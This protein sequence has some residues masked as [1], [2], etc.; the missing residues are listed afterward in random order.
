VLGLTIWVVA[1]VQ[2]RGPRSE[3]RAADPVEVILSSI[4]D[5]MPENVDEHFA[6]PTNAVTQV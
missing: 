2:G 5:D 4:H 1:R 3:V 6:A